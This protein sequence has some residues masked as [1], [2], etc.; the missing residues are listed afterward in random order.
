MD[1][2]RANTRRGLERARAQVRIGGR[3][4]VMTPDRL[5]EAERMRAEGKS[6]AHIAGVLGVGASSVNRALGRAEQPA[7]AG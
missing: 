5:A 4:T 2:I 7:E 3:L 1:T 6:I